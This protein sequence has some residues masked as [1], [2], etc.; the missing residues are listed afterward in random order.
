MTQEIGSAV[1]HDKKTSKKQAATRAI[2]FLLKYTPST[3]L[4]P[5]PVAPPEGPATSSALGRFPHKLSHLVRGA[6]PPG[7]IVTPRF[8]LVHLVRG[9]YPVLVWWDSSGLQPHLVVCLHFWLRLRLIVQGDNKDHVKL[10]FCSVS[11]SSV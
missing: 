7:L 2:D 5:A 1:E 10:G 6:Y 3:P 9:T 8:L 11:D 4:V